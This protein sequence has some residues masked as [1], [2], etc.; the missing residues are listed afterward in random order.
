M[1]LDEG[2]VTDTEAPALPEI[3]GGSMQDLDRLFGRAEQALDDRTAARQQAAEN[4]RT[5]Q[6]TIEQT[7][8]DLADRKLDR[9]QPVFEPQPF[10][11]PEEKFNPVEAFGSSAATLGLLASLLTKQPLT[12]ALNSSAAAMQAFRQRDIDAYDKA[13]SEWKANTD[14]AYKRAQFEQ[15]NYRDAM[16]MMNQDFNR[17]YAY[18]RTLA[19]LN[20][21][22]AAL[23]A[24]DTADPM[25]FVKL[26]DGR[27]KLTK[28]LLDNHDKLEREGLY[29]RAV[30]E[31]EQQKG[32]PLTPQEI[33]EIKNKIFTTPAQQSLME[34]T[35]AVTAREMEK[36][37]F[38]RLAHEDKQELATKKLEDTR[39]WRE[40]VAHW[41]ERGLDLKEAE[42]QAR[43]EI[44]SAELDI[45]REGLEAHKSP[46]RVAFDKFVAENPDA[47]AADQA[48]FI[49]SMKGGA[50]GPLSLSKFRADV[51]QRTLDE[52]EKEQGF[53]PTA[54][55]RMTVLHDVTKGGLTGN[56]KD[57]NQAQLDM[58]TY[59]LK[60]SDDALSILDKRLG[61]AGAAG[62]ARR[63]VESVSNVLGSESTDFAMFKSNIDYLQGMAGRLMS[64]SRGRPLSKEAEQ[65]RNVIGGLSLG[66]TTANMKAKL[67][68]VQKLYMQMMHDAESRLA[69]T[70]TPPSARGGEPTPEPAAE[71]EP[72]WRKAPTR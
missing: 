52:L 15:Q 27:E 37:D 11:A 71:E 17:G 5:R 64:A 50:S 43:Y 46:Q 67:E 24:L 8:K 61:A 4:I 14:I 47:T 32:A 3:T 57:Q 36:L 6:T 16:T 56:Q 70:W 59:S 28:S 62:Y 39:I 12:A 54:E 25:D 13:F 9:P 20:Q 34:R 60:A 40:R 23:A 51:A 21:D 55:Q 68:H 48:K 31:A 30:M 69:G 35:N 26:V 53:P 41:R 29:Q 2:E 49:Q 72:L 63:A 10:K 38:R 45:K 18:A 66:D 7:M 65:L 19:S 22:E 44:R 58:F 33:V 42:Q 1:A